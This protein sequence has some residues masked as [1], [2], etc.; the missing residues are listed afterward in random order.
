MSKLQ[1]AIISF[2]AFSISAVSSTKTGGFP[3]PAPIAFLPLDIT[4]FT[5]PGPPVATTILILGFAIIFSV[6]SILG[7][8]IVTTKLS[9]PPA[10]FIASFISSTA[11]IEVL[12]APGW[13]ANI[14]AFPA[15]I[16]PIELQITVSLGFVEGVIA[17]ITP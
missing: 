12:L 10:F 6:F 13:G 2:A 11:L 17:P 3:A 4:V 14:T 1:P 8:A 15:A 9:G 7:S 5:T 16:I